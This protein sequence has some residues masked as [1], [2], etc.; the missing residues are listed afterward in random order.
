MRAAAHNDG[1]ACN[2]ETKISACD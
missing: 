1:T 2:P